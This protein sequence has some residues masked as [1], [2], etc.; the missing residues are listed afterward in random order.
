MDNLPSAALQAELNKIYEDKFNIYALINKAK[1]S[2]NQKKDWH[3]PEPVLFRVCETYWKEKDRIRNQWTWFHRVLIQFSSE[4]FASKNEEE[5][6]KYKDDKPM[7]LAD[8]MQGAMKAAT[9]GMG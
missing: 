1:A 5:G 7:V 8:I 3:F 9:K 6:E 2:I 4:H